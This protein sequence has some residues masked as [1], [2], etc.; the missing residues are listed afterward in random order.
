MLA[1]H[2]CY[3]ER[4][5]GREHPSNWARTT[6]F[7]RF[8]KLGSDDLV[9]QVRQV[10]LGRLGSPDS[11]GWARA[12]WFVRF[13]RLGSGDLPSTRLWW[14]TARVSPVLFRSPE[15]PRH[16]SLYA[17]AGPV[18]RENSG[19]RAVSVLPRPQG[20]RLHGWH[21]LPKCPGTFLRAGDER[22]R[23]CAHRTLSVC[24]L[25]SVSWRYPT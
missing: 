18:A 10:G 17:T 14:G 16:A 21:S 19:P 5:S 6:W 24:V 15:G 9:R 20:P 23:A 3:D 7:P 11:S 8:V 12:T 1:D 4:C 2:G 22:G 13:A 25:R